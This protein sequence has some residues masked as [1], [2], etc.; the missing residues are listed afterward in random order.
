MLIITLSLVSDL[1]TNLHCSSFEWHPSNFFPASD[2][3][4]G[5][6]GVA[7]VFGDCD[8][9]WDGNSCAHVDIDNY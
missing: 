9:H 1:S 6:L 3:H 4:Y 5:A 2:L 7:A 8:S